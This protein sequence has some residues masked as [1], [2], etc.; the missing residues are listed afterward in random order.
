[1]RSHIT[2]L[3]KRQ[4]HPSGEKIGCYCTHPGGEHTHTCTHTHVHTS[5]APS[6]CIRQQS[7]QTPATAHNHLADTRVRER[8]RDRAPA[9]VPYNTITESNPVRERC[10]C[11]H[12]ITTVGKCELW[13]E[14]SW[15][16]QSYSCKHSLLCNYH[17]RPQFT[18]PSW[19]LERC[20][21]TRCCVYI[22]QIR[23]S[24]FNLE[25]HKGRREKCPDTA[26]A[27]TGAA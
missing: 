17:S 13:S 21:W 10:R 1:M 22:Q 15:Q 19:R 27:L 12:L 8:T 25:R 14:G 23:Y 20:G 16:R 3:R 4:L 11:M 6:S 18:A 7:Q 26:L 2:K 24:K 5:V 9:A